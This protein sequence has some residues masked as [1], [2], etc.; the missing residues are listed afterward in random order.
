MQYLKRY[1]AAC[2]GS[3]HAL[4]TSDA[5]LSTHLMLPLDLLSD[6]R[7]LYSVM[8]YC[9]GGELFD[10][11]DARAKFTEEE[12][13]FWMHQILDGLD[14]LQRAGICHR[15]MSL[16]NLL[17][18]KD[19]ICLIIDMGMCLRIPYEGSRDDGEDLFMSTEQRLAIERG[20]RGGRSDGGVAVAASVVS[21]A[22][23]NNEGEEDGGGKRPRAISA[24]TELRKSF[25]GMDLDSGD[26][27]G[28]ASGM[29]TSAI[30][31]AAASVAAEDDEDQCPPDIRQRQRYLIKPNGTCGKWHYMSP[32]IAKN[33]VPFDGHGEYLGIIFQ[34]D[35]ICVR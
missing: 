28:T 14:N 31:A 10:R 17:V 1:L 34:C 29:A 35:S 23:T 11:L 9:D 32:E 12:A 7:Y 19:R 18:H 4:D 21:D 25:M 6:D 13:R 30:A 2:S 16:E 20:G 5:M 24:N 8:P 26:G 15:D 27:S 22:N 33:E 3:P